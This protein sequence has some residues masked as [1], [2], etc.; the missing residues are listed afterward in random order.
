MILIH[1][2]YNNFSIFKESHLLL[3]IL[4]CLS[5]G[6]MDNNDTLSDETNTIWKKFFFFQTSNKE[7]IEKKLVKNWS[8]S[9]VIKVEV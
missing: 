1:A 4:I 5:S 9:E 7:N 2:I 8:S 3:K 6:P